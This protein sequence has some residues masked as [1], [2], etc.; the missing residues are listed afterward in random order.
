MRYLIIKRTI[1]V[2]VNLPT[3]SEQEAQLQQRDH[4]TCNVT[5]WKLKKQN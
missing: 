1:T 4:V 5:L 2:A 3:I